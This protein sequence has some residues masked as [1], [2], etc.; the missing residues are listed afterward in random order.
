LFPYALNKD[1]SNWV[2][3]LLLSQKQLFDK[4]HL[5]WQRN[6]HHFFLA[7][8]SGRC[9]GRIAAFIDK[10][11]NEFHHTREACFGF[12]EAENYTE[13]FKQLLVA[14]EGF[15][16][17]N[18]CAEIIGPINPSLHYEL[19]VLVNGFENPPYFMLTY[20]YNYYD[21]QIKA[22]GYRTLKDFYSYK[23]DSSQYVPTSKMKRVS[24]FL[25]QRYQIKIRSADIKSF[26]KELDILYS[27]Y[28]DAF[29]GH[30]GFTPIQ[31]DEFSLLAKDMKTI[32]DPRMVLVAEMN[33]EPIGFLLCIPNFNEL[34]I[35]IKDGRLFP[36]G[37][38]R[39]LSGRKKIRSARVITVAIKKKYQH[40]GV[41]ALLYPEIMKRGLQFNYPECEL[42][43]VVED[44]AIMNQVARDLS[45][46]PYK[47]YRLYSKKI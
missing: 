11:H 2:P 3:P 31:K 27:I 40:L 41:G 12:L 6:P 44:N 37:I 34:F 24:A 26:N 17:E 46:N 15:A 8:S 18:N 10:E 33:T 9:V 23:L 39:L 14:A 7:F 28:N 5:F 13:I 30:W 25:Q 29:I 45:A 20:N 38:F 32:I 22:C 1:N 21:G 35:K 19:G 4:K 43:W 47:T 36:T 42:S 16:R